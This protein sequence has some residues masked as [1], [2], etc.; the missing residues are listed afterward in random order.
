MIGAM[1]Q[2]IPISR[3]WWQ[4]LRATGLHAALV[5]IACIRQARRRARENRELRALDASTLRDLGVDRSELPSYRVESD[6]RAA[7]TRLRVAPRAA[8]V[9]AARY[10][11]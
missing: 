8:A 5:L 10:S 1:N 6:G 7:R 4:R 2:P 9:E 3:P 11:A